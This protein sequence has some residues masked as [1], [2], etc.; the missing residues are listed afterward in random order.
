MSENTT[1]K[2]DAAS[3]PMGSY[4]SALTPRQMLAAQLRDLGYHV[5]DTDRCTLCKAAEEL[6]K[7]EKPAI[8]PFWA[9]LP[10]MFGGVDI[11]P[12]GMKAYMDAV[13]KKKKENTDRKD[14]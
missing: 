12:D 6:D 10:L 11:D 8:S 9:L 7:P 14:V 13:Q 1:T 3:L 5:S 4:C 2:S